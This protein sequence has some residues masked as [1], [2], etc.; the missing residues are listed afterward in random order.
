MKFLGVYENNQFNIL[1]WNLDSNWHQA[2]LRRPRKHLIYMCCIRIWPHLGFYLNWNRDNSEHTMIQHTSSWSTPQSLFRFAYSPCC[3]H[4]PLQIPLQQQQPIQRGR[5]QGFTAKRK[6]SPAG[7]PP[8]ALSSP[9][10]KSLSL[11]VFSIFCWQQRK[12]G[13]DVH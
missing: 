13:R 1:L 11:S 7:A 3:L 5:D 12:L 6:Y 8:S 2:T 9:L 4:L 10:Q